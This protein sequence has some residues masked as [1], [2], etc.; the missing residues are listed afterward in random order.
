MHT[1]GISN[2]ESERMILEC[3]PQFCLRPV[4]YDMRLV[5]TF[6]IFM[7]DVMS[8][9]LLTPKLVAFYAKLNET[10]K[11]EFHFALE[12]SF[13]IYVYSRLWLIYLDSVVLRHLE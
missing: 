3:T 12:V 4:L 9:S 6:I 8:Y 7:Y 13:N 2:A 1:E 5:T 10:K 11:F